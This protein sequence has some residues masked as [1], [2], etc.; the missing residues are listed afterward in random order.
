MSFSCLPTS[1]RSR[2][3]KTSPRTWEANRSHSQGAGSHGWPAVVIIFLGVVLSDEERN[4]PS[5]CYRAGASGPLLAREASRAWKCSV[6]PLSW[7]TKPHLWLWWLV[8]CMCGR[9]MGKHLE[10]AAVILCDCEELVPGQRGIR[11]LPTQLVLKA[12]QNQVNHL[13]H[14]KHYYTYY[15]QN[16]SWGI[17]EKRLLPSYD[18]EDNVNDEEFL[19]PA[20]CA[21]TVSGN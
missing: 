6:S 19:G 10:A 20:L 2:H 7:M 9:V 11:C 17:Q 16:R 12:Q 21:G 8:F 13:F 1:C 15:Q 18:K 5:S 4:R 3:S 14:R